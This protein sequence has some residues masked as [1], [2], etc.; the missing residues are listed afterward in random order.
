MYVNENYISSRS[1][2]GAHIDEI[3]KITSISKPCS[4]YLQK[5]VK[6]ERKAELEDE[7]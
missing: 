6:Y 5:S 2:G 1:L 3:M 7:E 4:P